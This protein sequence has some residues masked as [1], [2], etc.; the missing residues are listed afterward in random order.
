M[1][2]KFEFLFNII[3]VGAI[4]MILLLAL[5]FQ[6]YLKELPCPLCLLQRVGFVMMIYGLL[7]NLKYGYRPS[8]YSIVLI[9]GLFTASV[10]LRQ[11]ALHII[12]GT[13]SYGSPVF[14]LHLYTWSFIISMTI[15]F[16]TSLM[17]ALDRQYYQTTDA[18]F[19]H[20]GITG[21]IFLIIGLI[22]MGNFVTTL[23][24]CGLTACPDNPTVYKLLTSTLK[25]L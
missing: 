25:F 10:A 8:H 22:V 12:P 17:L 13:G 4:G 5:T 3:E 7:L 23:L 18:S 24:E 20:R 19:L 9:S 21:L 2:I 14:G 16:V 15:V 11:V 1:K 6:L